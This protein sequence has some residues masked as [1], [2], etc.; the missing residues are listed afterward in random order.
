MNRLRRAGVL[1]KKEMQ[2]YSS[3]VILK[4]REAYRNSDVAKS[5]TVSETWKLSKMF[6]DPSLC[7]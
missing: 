4:A 5:H 6:E 1:Y 2:D 7:T 3:F